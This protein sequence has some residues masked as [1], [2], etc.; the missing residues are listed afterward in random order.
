[1]A[2]EQGIPVTIEITERGHRLIERQAREGIYAPLLSDHALI[3]AC[4]TSRIRE[5]EDAG[6]RLYVATFE[7][8]EQRTFAVNAAGFA[9]VY[10][11]EYGE[12]ILHSKMVDVRWMR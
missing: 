12:R 3:D 10:A 9:R 7:N 4:S 1:M 11:R 8:G 2:S 6:R 5:Y